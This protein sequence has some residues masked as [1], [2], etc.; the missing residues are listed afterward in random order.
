MKRTFTITETAVYE[1]DLDVEPGES[2][3]EAAE[4]YFLNLEDIN[5]H[6]HCV[7]ERSIVGRPTSDEEA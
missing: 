3:E 6:F 2:P 1:F 5:I 4:Q 7:E